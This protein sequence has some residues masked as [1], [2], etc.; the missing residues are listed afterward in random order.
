MKE[1]RK[2]GLEE[3][4]NADSVLFRVFVDLIEEF[5][6]LRNAGSVTSEGHESLV[7]KDELSDG[8]GEIDLQQDNN[9]NDDRKS[10]SRS[11]SISK[12]EDCSF[13]SSVIESLDRNCEGK[14]ERKEEEQTR[15]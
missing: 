10:I 13:L 14:E 9:N 12:Q 4:T 15:I 7:Q 11:V 8:L 6:Q 5:V 2:R 3:G 1:T